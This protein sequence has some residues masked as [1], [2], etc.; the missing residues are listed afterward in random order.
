MSTLEHADTVVLIHGTC[1]KPLSWEHW[2]S[3]YTARGY[4]VIATGVP[5]EAST[6]DCL[7][8][9]DAGTASTII[10]YY[11]RLLMTV[12]KPPILIG[13]CFG[14]EVVQLLLDRGFGAAG[15]A[16]SAPPA[17][18]RRAR[19]FGFAARV[20]RRAEL[21]GVDYS[22]GNRAPL[23]LV[24]AGLDFNVP[25]ELVEATALRYQESDAPAGYLEYPGACHHALRS[26]GW[27]QLADDVLDWAELY[28]APDRL[29]AAG[30]WKP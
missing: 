8:P 27:E 22:S 7:S 25:S 26:P 18:E 1:V 10:T 3:R 28:A 15:V 12:P 17:T 14:G 30:R 2:M 13:H 5:D 23:L 6:D 21:P 9:R 19:G 20:G 29:A 16:I 11:E 4:C 24:G